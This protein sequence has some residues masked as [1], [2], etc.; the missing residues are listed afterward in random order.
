VDT[1]AA[2]T[3]EEADTVMD[4][5]E[6]FLIQLGFLA[7]TPRGRVATPAA[8]K[9]LGRTPPARPLASDDRQGQLF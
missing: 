5:Y 2:A 3:S 8:Y 4:V 1:I 6:P 9:H 7:R